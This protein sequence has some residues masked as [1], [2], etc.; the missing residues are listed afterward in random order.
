MLSIT[1]TTRQST[2]PG[3]DV[4]RLLCPISLLIPILA[5][6]MGCKVGPD[7]VRP[8]ME[9]PSSWAGADDN[10][11]GDASPPPDD[12][13]G[14]QSSTGTDESTLLNWWTAFNDPTLTSLINR[15]FDS[16][17]NLKMATSRIMQARASRGMAAA[18]AGPTLD[19]NAA[20]RIGNSANS[21][22]TSGTFQAGF[23]AGWEID[24]FGSV[25]RSI[26]VADAQLLAAEHDRDD[27]LITLAAEVAINYADLRS[28]QQRLE[29]T[30][31]NLE[32]QE[33]TARLTRQRFEG[34][35]VSGL[36]VAN[37]EAQV[38][39]TASQIPLLESSVR[40]SIHSLSLLLGQAPGALMT[41]LTTPSP[42]P[43]APPEVPTGIPSDILRRRPDIRSTEAGIH[44][45]TARIGVAKSDFYPRFT[46]GGGLNLQSAGADLLL[47]P[48][49]LFWS[50]GPSVKWNLF[51]SN[52]TVSNVKLQEALQEQSVLAYRQVVL[53]AM[54]EVEDAMVASAKEEEHRQHVQIALEASQKALEL[55]TMLYTEG[56]TDFL[57]VIAAQRSLYQLE[58]SLVASTRNMTI[59]LISLYKALGGGW[60]W[61]GESRPAESS[62]SIP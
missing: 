8:D 34:G 38:A 62:I 19:G 39:G 26:E 15:A 32:L 54:R 48:L 41:E 45:A 2:V 18:G 36:D 53:Q 61:E 40:Q 44:A 51:Q 59:E 37:A 35:F 33:H 20:W 55:A 3:R 24:I 42:I 14:E 30:R 58:E 28:S 56:Q 17:L 43:I 57:N 16:N 49:N 1:P 29:L 5:F 11:P 13:S 9:M 46:L 21:D 4:R 23:D 52:R 31:K 27:V 12:R 22:G 10:H 60:D 50:I 25:R 7:Y 6:F 47:N